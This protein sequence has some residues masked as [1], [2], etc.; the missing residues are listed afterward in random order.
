MYVQGKK[1]GWSCF[2]LCATEEPIAQDPWMTHELRDT[3]S[4]EEGRDWP[5]NVVVFTAPLHLFP[6]LRALDGNP[7]AEETPQSILPIQP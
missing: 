2:D 7:G 1:P 4:Y 3:G 5:P 6:A